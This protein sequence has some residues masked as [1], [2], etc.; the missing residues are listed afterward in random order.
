MS[1]TIKNEE[2]KDEEV[3]IEP[4]EGEVVDSEEAKAESK[5]KKVW[6]KIKKPVSYIGAAIGGFA[7]AMILANAKEEDTEDGL[8]YLENKEEDSSN[9]TEE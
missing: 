1:K 4:I 6:G 8:Y 2:V 7:V 5:I 3:V 9:E